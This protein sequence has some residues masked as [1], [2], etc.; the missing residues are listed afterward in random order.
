M[1]TK[2]EIE[3]E[4]ERRERADQDKA[5]EQAKLAIHIRDAE[6]ARKKRSQSQ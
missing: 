2:E 4:K 6:E 5:L 1:P 3:K